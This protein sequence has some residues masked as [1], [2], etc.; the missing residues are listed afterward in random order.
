MSLRP[1]ADPDAEA[2]AALHALSFAA[3][4]SA[5]EMRELMRGPGG[6]GLVIE[7]PAGRAL[8]GFILCRMLAGE[9]EVL[10]LAVDPTERGRGLGGV[11]LRAALDLAATAGGEAMFLEV[12]ADN[13]PAIALY[14]RAGFEPVGQRRGYY[15]RQDGP[16]VDA[17]V[18]RR[19]LAP[20]HQG[21]S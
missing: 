4:W 16:A 2:M 13:A 11:L 15:A 3:S 21:Q 19:D 7:A 14:R 18:Y 9:A 12:A 5:G 20:S 1:A 6:Y 10:T 8:A 17:L